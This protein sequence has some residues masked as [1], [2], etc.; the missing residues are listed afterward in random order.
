MCRF[1]PLCGQSLFTLTE[2]CL[3]E[4]YVECGISLTEQPHFAR[5]HPLLNLPCPHKLCLRRSL[6]SLTN[7]LNQQHRHSFTNDQC[8]CSYYRRNY[9]KAR[10]CTCGVPVKSDQERLRQ[11][12]DNFHT[13]I[14]TAN[15]VKLAID[16]GLKVPDVQR[17]LSIVDVGISVFF[18]ALDTAKNRSTN[19]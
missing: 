1:H 9:Q 8:P 13:V 6:V 5:M 3:L 2:L 4:I 19:I 15:A 12:I 16:H 14:D 17:I 11:Y 7:F 10:R 18:G